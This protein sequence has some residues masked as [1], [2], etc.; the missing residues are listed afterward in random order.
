MKRNNCC[1]AGLCI[2]S[3]VLSLQHAWS[4][5]TQRTNTLQSCYV[6]NC[7]LNNCCCCCMP[8]QQAIARVRNDDD[9]AEYCVAVFTAAIKL[10]LEDIGQGSTAAA[11]KLPA[12]S[13]AY[14]LVRVKETID[15]SETVKFCF[16]KWSP[17]E[18]VAPAVR[19]RLGVLSGAVAKCNHWSLHGHAC[20]VYSIVSCLSS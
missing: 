3:H 13:F 14:A 9:P 18:G 17:E 2:Q 1:H 20:T 15:A 8:L 4:R 6:C 19:G 12:D 7:I 11:A 16:V 10:K 5:R